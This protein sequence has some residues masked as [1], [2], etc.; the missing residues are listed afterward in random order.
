MLLTDLAIAGRNLTR[1]TRR[2]LFLGGALAAVTGLLVLLGALTS[3][4]EAAMMESAT[5]LMTGH[6]NVGGLLQDHHRLRRPARLRLPEGAGAGA[7]RRPGARLRDGAGPRLGQG[8][9]RGAVDGPRASPGSTSR[10][11]R[12][13]ARGAPA[14]GGAL[15]DLA[16]PNTMLLFEGQAQRLR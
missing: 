7:P 11:S 14:R 5:T 16:S 9:L 12:P 13:S 10:A 1:H 2:N 6:V 15:D 8:G 3:G 4:I